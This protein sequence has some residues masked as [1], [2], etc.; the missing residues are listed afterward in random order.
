MTSL[1]SRSFF[2]R[3]TRMKQGPRQCQTGGMGMEG[4]MSRQKRKSRIERHPRMYVC[5]EVSTKASLFVTCP[6]PLSPSL[7]P[8]FEPD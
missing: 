7:G 5:L 3:V 6:Q 1:H 2:L 8:P 4:A